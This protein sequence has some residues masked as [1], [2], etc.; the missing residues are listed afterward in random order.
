MNNLGTFEDLKPQRVLSYDW[1]VSVAGIIE[2][3]WQFRDSTASLTLF[4]W[5]DEGRA[6]KRSHRGVGT[7]LKFAIASKDF[8]WQIKIIKN[9]INWLNRSPANKLPYEYRYNKDGTIVKVK[10]VVGYKAF[11]DLLKP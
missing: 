3:G 7:I 1:Y 8:E 10:S 2:I 4:Q 6:H 11:E 9:L 5:S